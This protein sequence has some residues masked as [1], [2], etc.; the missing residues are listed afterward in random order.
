[1]SDFMNNLNKVGMILQAGGG[2]LAGRDGMGVVREYQAQ[3]EDERRRAAI[4]GLLQQS[5]IGGVQ[6]G[7]IEQLPVGEQAPVILNMLAQM[8]AQRRAGGAAGAAAARQAAEEA[9][10]Q[11]FLR[12]IMGGGQPQQAPG[13]FSLGE[14]VTN[15]VPP[16]QPLS[17]GSAAPQPTFFGSPM[18]SAPA[19][20]GSGVA[21][22]LSFGQITPTPPPP[23]PEPFQIGPAAI[24]QAIV[25]YGAGSDIVKDLR[26]LYEIQQPVAPDLSEA[27]QEIARLTGI[28]VPYNVA[29]KMKEGALTTSRDPD[30]GDVLVLDLSTVPPSVVWS[31]EALRTGAGT[32]PP[33]TAGT[34]ADVPA[35]APERLT[36]GE[37]YTDSA[38]SFGLEGFGRWAANT[39]ADVIPGAGTPFPETMQTQADF[40][41]LRETLL[42]NVAEGYGRQPPSWLL[43]EIR[44]LTPEAGSFRQGPE[45]AQ[46]KLR[47]LGRLME[48]EL[49]SAERALNSNLRLGPTERQQV[50]ARAATLRSSL[51]Q[52]ESAL[53]SF[54]GA[55]IRPD[56]ADRLKAYE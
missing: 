19:P 50:Q 31:S 8:E 46:T 6:R 36:F 45:E 18:A 56:V 30:T 49:M 48:G 51:A 16:S 54:G 11:A 22:P 41:V 10:R 1:M 9:D 29:V 2:S 17:F 12:E 7:L 27:E 34:P 25:K 4:A 35:T 53:G 33:P 13:G 23:D 43:Q 38:N 5:G 20:V 32:P 37:A 28:G 14:S 55:V 42:N 26:A 39:A 52:I 21:P 24:Q 44:K 40:A 15:I 3:Q 47:A